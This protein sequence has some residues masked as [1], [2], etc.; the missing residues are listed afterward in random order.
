MVE[1]KVVPNSAE[2]GLKAEKNVLVAFVRSKPERDRANAELVRELGRLLACKVR[3]VR[4]F[5]KRKKLLDIG[6]DADAFKERT[7]IR[8]QA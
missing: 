2:F 4:G 3:I 1:V 7:G 8:L 6:V 5:G